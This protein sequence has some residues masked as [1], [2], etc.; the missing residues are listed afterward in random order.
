[1]VIES[2]PG[3]WQDTSHIFGCDVGRPASRIVGNPL[4]LPACVKNILPPVATSPT[5]QGAD[6]IPRSPGGTFTRF[7]TA[8][9][10]CNSLSGPAGLLS[11]V[12]PLGPGGPGGPRSPYPPDREIIGA[13][14]LPSA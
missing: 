11:P 9:V 10:T 2:E 1:M 3:F 14:A 13:K 4:E 7:P 12:S 5:E 6:A 8:V